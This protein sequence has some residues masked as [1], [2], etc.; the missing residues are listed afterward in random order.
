MRPIILKGGTQP[1]T[2][3]KYNSDGDLIFTASKD[4]SGISVWW[5][6]S[7][8][9]IGTFDNH[10]G[11]VYSIDINHSST[12][13][14]SGAADNTARLWDVESGK[15][16]CTF[17]HDQ[18]T[19]RFVR[20]VSF[21][22]GAQRFFSL[23]EQP[24]QQ[25]PLIR[26]F[27]VCEDWRDQ[28]KN[29]KP[30]QVIE[31]NIKD[32]KIQVGLW[33]WHNET[34]ITGHSNGMIRLYD[35][36]KGKEISKIEAHTKVVT[37]LQFEKYRGVFLSASKDGSAKLIDTRSLEVI[38]VYETGRPL[39]AASI[40]PLMDHV[41]VGGGERAEEVTVTETTASQFKVRFYHSIFC[42]ELGSI[43]G[44]FGPVNALAFSPDGR[45]FASGGQDGFVRV[46]HFGDDYLGRTD[47]ITKYE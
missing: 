2:D 10:T 24:A 39:N 36:E 19:N 14:I 28:P 20:Q 22:V 6:D 44:H 27:K 25:V 26:I 29:T 47:E 12:R 35:V 16:L 15:E 8:E 3:V 41:I 17:P 33:G 32:D 40:S 4:K 37:S 43:L 30:I 21:S 9:R 31:S 23:T 11:A 7:G 5:S 13:M 18:T 1:I 38:K 42:T 45:Q 46:H 34:I